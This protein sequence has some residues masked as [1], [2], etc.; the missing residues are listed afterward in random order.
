MSTFLEL[1]HQHLIQLYGITE[2]P[3]ALN[4]VF[5]FAAD[6]LDVYIKTER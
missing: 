4:F 2:A 6:S 1:K 3:K 5:E